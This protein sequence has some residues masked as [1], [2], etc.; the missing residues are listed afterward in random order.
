V[1]RLIVAV[2][3]QLRR[4]FGVAV[5]AGCLPFGAFTG[6]EVSQRWLIVDDR[7]VCD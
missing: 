5:L 3:F 7:S 1:D 2:I 4:P 6:R